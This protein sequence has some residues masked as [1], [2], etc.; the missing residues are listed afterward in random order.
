MQ[1]T[2]TV[3][4]T[5]DLVDEFYC[6]KTITLKFCDSD[7]DGLTFVI[8]K[9]IVTDDVTNNFSYTLPRLRYDLQIT[10]LYFLREVLDVDAQSGN[11]SLGTI[12]LLNGN[13][14]GAGGVPDN[15]V[16]DYDLDLV[17][18]VFDECS[19]SMGYDAR[20]DFNCDGCVDIFD[21]DIV[22]RNY[23]EVGDSAAD[24]GPP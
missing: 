8:E 9:T 16:D 17:T 3:S 2:V 15:T 21:L 19:P 5:I 12:E 6:E 24:C 7:V 23:N 22:I 14:T 1:T 20:A 4:G 13:G 10:S 11:V 18:L